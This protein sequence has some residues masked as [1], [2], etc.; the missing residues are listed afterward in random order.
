[1]SGEGKK[2]NIWAIMGATGGGKGNTVK[3]FYQRIKP[4]RSIIWDGLHDFNEHG[5]T[6]TTLGELYQAVKI[7]NGYRKHF[8]IVFKPSLKYRNEKV[9]NLVCKLVYAVGDLLFIADELKHVTRAIQSPEWWSEI[10]TSGRH[11]G[12]SVIGTSQR[13]A[14]IDKDF[15]SAATHIRAF[16]MNFDS[17][18]KVLA[19]ALHVKKDEVSGL[20]EYNHIERDMKTGVTT[21]GQEKEYKPKKR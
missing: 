5:Q 18:V 19:D 13:P 8:N 20:P 4:K 14:Q 2:A 6:V 12:L 10:N 17:D 11:R 7:K 9:F 1:M 3:I 16:R 15:F 21:T